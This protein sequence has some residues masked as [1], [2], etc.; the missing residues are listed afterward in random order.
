M[1]VWL[2]GSHVK[3]VG[4]CAKCSTTD[5]TGHDYVC[6][7]IFDVF[8]TRVSWVLSVTNIICNYCTPLVSFGHVCGCMCTEYIYSMSP[9]F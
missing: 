2:H 1:N 9:V 5:D 6:S 8:L 3:H 4:V 7:S